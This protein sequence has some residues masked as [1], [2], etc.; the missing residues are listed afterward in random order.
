M[1]MIRWLLFAMALLAGPTQATIEVQ[2]FDDPGLAERYEGL[3]RRLRCPMCQNES[4]AASNSPIAADMRERVATLLRNG[5]TDTAIEDALVERFGDY[6]R[7]DPR[8][9]ARTWILWG[10]PLGLVAIGGG[11]VAAFVIRR[12]RQVPNRL[13]END[14][15]R[16]QALITR[17]HEARD[18]RRG[19]DL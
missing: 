15:Q 16:L 14:R 2:S 5:A 6:I 4:I 13:C 12:R 18:L 1:A 11:I 7:Y 9:E 3:S 17:H 19:D 10:L 8:F